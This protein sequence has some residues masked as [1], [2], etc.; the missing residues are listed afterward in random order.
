MDSHDPEIQREISKSE[1]RAV[2]RDIKKR[3]TAYALRIIR[4]YEALPKR[5]AV[6]VIT[7]QLLK[8]GTSPGAHYRE[9]CRAKSNADFISKMEGGLQELDE[10][11]YWLELL[12]EGN[13][14]EKT[15][16]QSLQ[17]ETQELIRIFVTMVKKAKGRGKQ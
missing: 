14:I 9:A 11:D 17:I 3:L 4:L 5:G 6:H 16:I 2:S 15:K 12:V 8:S 10:S 7:F 1:D 13:Y